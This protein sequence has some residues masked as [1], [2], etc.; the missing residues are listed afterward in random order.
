MKD[1]SEV[2]P[3]NIRPKE[4]ELFSS[5]LVRLAYSHQIKPHDFYGILFPKFNIYSTDIDKSASDKFIQLLESKTTA[6]YDELLST[7]LRYY[8]GKLYLTHNLYGNTKW[9]LPLE[10]A[11]KT[12]ESF[13]MVFCPECLKRDKDPYFRK[14]WRLSISI[15]CVKCGIYLHEKCPN[16]HKSISFYKNDLKEE[17]EHTEHSLINCYNCHF[18]LSHAISKRAS[19][20]YIKKQIELFRIINEGWNQ[21]VIYPHLY[22]E[23]LHQILKII[24][25]KAYSTEGKRSNTKTAI[26][27]LLPID[28]RKKHLSMA[29]WMLED[30]PGR[31]VKIS[32]KEKFTR[33]RLFKDFKD[34]PFWY[35]DFVI[36]NFFISNMDNPF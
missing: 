19:S 5:W 35:Y 7:T 15:I 27:E 3:G 8:E 34:I 25:N 28:L 17:T 1:L 22:F 23:V 9:I 36:G 10:S 26:F 20:K 18:D 21:K 33:T 14:H 24:I 29:I 11:H 13:G 4:D 32:Q 12:Y 16:C 30:F 31:F 6:T 2:L